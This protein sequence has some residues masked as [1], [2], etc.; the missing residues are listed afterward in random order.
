MK[1]VGISSLEVELAE[2][3][4]LAHDGVL[5]ELGA[6]GMPASLLAIIRLECLVLGAHR[7]RARAGDG[8]PRLDVGSGRRTSQQDV[9]V[10]ELLDR[11]LVV[12]HGDAL[13]VTPS[14]SVRAS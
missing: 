11:R 4:Q 14:L 3:K 10:L 9:A 13:T 1:N 6:P 7:D 12:G 8:Q 2:P 5:G